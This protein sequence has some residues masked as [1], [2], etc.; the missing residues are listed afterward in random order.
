MNQIEEVRMHRALPTLAVIILVMM[1]SITSACTAQSS[2]QELEAEVADLKEEVAKLRKELDEVLALAPIQQLI[3]EN[4]PLDIS[5]SVEDSPSL[6]DEDA[7]LTLV[8]FSDFQCPYCGRHAANTLPSL[9]DQYVETGKVKYVFFDFPLGN[10]KLAPKAS[11]AAHCAGE[12][13]KFW[14]MHDELFANQRA[15]QPEQLP[16]YA[17]KVGVSDMTAFQECLDADKYASHIEARVRDGAQLRVSGTPSFGLGY[18]EEDGKSVRVVKLIR[19]A[20]PLPQF[21]AQI[22]ELLDS[23]PP[24]GTD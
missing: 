2:P 17:E 15:L 12:Q 13:G 3:M 10:H 9:K 1:V 20:Q 7:K 8:E 14:E 11:E 19:G 22:D 21:Q 16:G 18:T 24:S 4:R 23:D 6:G 5:L